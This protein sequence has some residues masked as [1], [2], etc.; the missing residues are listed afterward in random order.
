MARKTKG[1]VVTFKQRGRKALQKSKV[2]KTETQAKNAIKRFNK[3]EKKM[4]ADLPSKDRTKLFFGHK[5]KKV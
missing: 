2:F 5:V 1:F 3:L 4:D